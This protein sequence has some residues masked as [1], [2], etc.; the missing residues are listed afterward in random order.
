MPGGSLVVCR[1][2][3]DAAVLH[4]ITA[5]TPGY[6]ATE[7]GFTIQSP[8]RPRFCLRML[9]WPRTFCFGL[10]ALVFA[11]KLGR[12]I[13]RVTRNALRDTGFQKRR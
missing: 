10:V 2:W 4:L 7:H 3:L 8:Q 5:F 9:P 6:Q 12:W 1:L 11:V 13:H